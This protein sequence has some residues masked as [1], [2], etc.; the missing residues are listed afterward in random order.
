ME[1]NAEEEAKRLLAGVLTKI[2][3]DL[4]AKLRDQL[5]KQLRDSG[6]HVGRVISQDGDYPSS[7]VHV[8]GMGITPHKKVLVIEMLNDLDVLM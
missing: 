2:Q 5:K 3:A 1:S 4:L 8:Y 6:V 7:T